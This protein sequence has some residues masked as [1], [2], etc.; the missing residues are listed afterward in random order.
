MTEDRREDPFWRW[1]DYIGVSNN[2]VHFT[3]GSYRLV[4]IA[5]VLYPGN[6]PR[7]TLFILKYSE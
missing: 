5:E 2:M 6:D 3:H 7:K 1:E 4:D